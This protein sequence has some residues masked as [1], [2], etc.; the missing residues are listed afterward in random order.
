M[1]KK[2]LLTF[3]TAILTIT[4][5]FSQTKSLPNVDLKTLDGSKSK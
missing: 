2:T 5:C 1:F 4:V 3:L